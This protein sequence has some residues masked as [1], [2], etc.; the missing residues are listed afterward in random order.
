MRLD[1]VAQTHAVA[2]SSSRYRFLVDEMARE[3]TRRVTSG[4]WK[5][6]HTLG[7]VLSAIAMVGPEFLDS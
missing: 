4:R 7:V 5:D 3:D 6:L 2:C 1:R